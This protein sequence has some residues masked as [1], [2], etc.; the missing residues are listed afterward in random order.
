MTDNRPSWDEYFMKITQV[1]A[2]RSTCIRRRVGA[3]VV[4]N[5][6]ILATGYNGAPSGLAHCGE[7][8]CLRQQQNIPSGERQE[9][10]RGL[11]AEQNAIIQ[12]SL[13][14]FS[15]DGAAMYCTNQPCITC[16]KMVINAGIVRVVFQG[17][18]PDPLSLGMLEEA[19][20]EVARFVSASGA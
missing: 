16:A 8:G 18:Y 1:V 10:C 2:E 7:A 6:R 14:G 19:G 12:A 17:D 15:I 9:I 5:K 3:I 11:H 20:V 13:Y 4:K